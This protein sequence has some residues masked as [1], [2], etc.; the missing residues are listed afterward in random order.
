[1]S[2]LL[3]VASGGTGRGQEATS[4]PP[5]GKAPTARAGTGTLWTLQQR[6]SAVMGLGCCYETS[7][8]RGHLTS[9]I[10]PNSNG[11]R[12]ER[13]QNHPVCP[14]HQKCNRDALNSCSCPGEGEKLGLLLF[15][16]KHPTCKL[17]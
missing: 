2:P 10:I 8:I 3:L 13:P 1:M 14:K 16:L 9:S 17:R 5:T 12:A 6:P 11:A 15:F 7:S 4:S